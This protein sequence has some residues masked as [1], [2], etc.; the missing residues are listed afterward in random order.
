MHRLAQELQELE[1]LRRT[2][3]HRSLELPRGIDFTSNDYLGL[4][5][6]PALRRAMID[7]LN[8]DAPVGAA[9]SRLLRG[10]QPGHAAL[11]TFAASFFGCE[12]TLYFATGFVANYALF[13]A[14]VHRH[15]AV[16]FDEL[17]HASA[18][19]GIHAA[20]ARRF[21]ARHNDV[22]AFDDALAR[23]RRAGARR[24]W[25]AVESVYSMDGDL[26][27]IDALIDLARSHEAMLVVDEAHASGVFG[28][29]GRG[30]TEGRH[31][32]SLISLHTCGKALGVAG[33]LVCGPAAAI[34]YLVNTSR[35]FIYS[36]APPPVVAV[37]VARALR[38]VDEEPWRRR[39]LFDLSALARGRLGAIEGVRLPSTAASQI[40]PLILGS[41]GRALAV[42]AHLRAAGFDVRA[43]RPPTVPPGTSRLRIAVGVDRSEDEIEALAGAL[44]EALARDAA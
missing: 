36:T 31:D 6:H 27:P 1:R 13:T 41:E 42:A 28:A 14:L 7:A 44:T 9:G 26:A 10:H 43:I 16:V 32:S 40:V 3:R 30:L 33:A 5:R 12:K 37:A 18:K 23:A 39:R 11:E 24:L 22:A 19:E 34:D 35:P 38:L 4:S 25:I 29:R 15:D 21:K 17:I 2:H 8:E 20:P